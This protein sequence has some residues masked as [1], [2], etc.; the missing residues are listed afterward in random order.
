VRLPGLAAAVT[1]TQVVF[2]GVFEVVGGITASG[3][4][5]GGHQHG[6]LVLQSN[7][8][9]ADPSLISASPGMLAAHVAAAAVTAVLL[10]RGELL[11][12]TIARWVRALFR[13]RQPVR[14]YGDDT[15]IPVSRTVPRAASRLLDD[16]A[17]RRG[18]PARASRIAFG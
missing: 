1:A 3:L 17:W 13:T 2:H 10:W 18:P 15:R 7:P 8:G 11:V 14:S 6:P 12:Q 5:L 9:A 4:A 16:C